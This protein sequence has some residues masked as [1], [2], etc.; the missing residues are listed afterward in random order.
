ML[1]GAKDDNSRPKG[2]GLGFG[3]PCQIGQTAPGPA[4]ERAEGAG[5]GWRRLPRIEVPDRVVHH[6]RSLAGVIDL[7]VNT[8]MAHP[9]GAAAVFVPV[10][11][12]RD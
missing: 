1:I 12:P 10:C 6:P 9:G 8:T 7:L 3:G 5:T 2:L 11:C 4:P